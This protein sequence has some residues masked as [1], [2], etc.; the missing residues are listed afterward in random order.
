MFVP[1]LQTVATPYAQPPTT[2]KIMSPLLNGGINNNH[3]ITIA[4]NQIWW[5]ENC[6]SLPDGIA[7]AQG[8]NQLNSTTYSNGFVYNTHLNGKDYLLVFSGSV[9]QEYYTGISYTASSNFTA[10]SIANWQNQQTLILDP[11]NAYL[12]W[13]GS[14]F[15]LI[16]STVKGYYL[17]V[18]QGRVYYVSPNQNALVYS[19][20]LSYDNWSLASGGGVILFTDSELKNVIYDLQ[21]YQNSLFILGDNGLYTLTWYGVL[22]GYLTPQISLVQNGFHAIPYGLTLWYGTPLV[23]GQNAIYTTQH[24]V[25]TQNFPSLQIQWTAYKNYLNKYPALVVYGIVQD[26]MHYQQ[27]TPVLLVYFNNTWNVI[28]YGMSFYHITPYPD[29]QNRLFGIS[30]SGL[31]EI[32]SD[33]VSQSSYFIISGDPNKERQTVSLRCLRFGAYYTVEGNNVPTFS[34]G[35]NTLNLNIL[36]SGFTEV[37]NQP[38]N[39]SAANLLALWSPSATWT[40][41]SNSTEYFYFPAAY[42]LSPVFPVSQSSNAYGVLYSYL[43][44]SNANPNDRLLNLIWEI[45]PIA[46][47]F[48]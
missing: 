35:V 47:V 46:D 23:S 16:D 34:G 33:T 1:A 22:E 4:P 48:G 12:S 18:W 29:S 27:T 44:V 36:N 40:N 38:Q 8:Y 6:V 2:Q 13:N 7:V 24:Q 41:A 5:G 45:E 14:S 39:M 17:T 3:P 11:N 25:L 26:V 30:S 9:V 10:P 28:N 42:I 37:N 21:P 20:P 31:F 43:S 15:S 32:L 19:A